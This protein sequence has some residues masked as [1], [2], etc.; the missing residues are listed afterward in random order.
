V[1]NSSKFQ[2]HDLT[3]PLSQTE[4]AKNVA[5]LTFWYQTCKNSIVGQNAAC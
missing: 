1:K 2:R 4:Q 5:L 3:V